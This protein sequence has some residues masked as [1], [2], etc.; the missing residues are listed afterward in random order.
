MTSLVILDSD[1]MGIRQ[2][3]RSAIAAALKL[4]VDVH[5][6]L[7][8]FD[9]R[10]S[11]QE[12]VKIAGLSKVLVADETSFSHSLAEL[13]SALIVS[14][15]GNY[16]HIISAA[17]AVGKNVMPRVPKTWSVPHFSWRRAALPSSAVRP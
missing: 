12:A 6:L 17:T 10:T 1:A 2:S 3:A 11:A 16:S 9:V 13:L 7:S 14:L 15:G 8:G 5:G 4:G